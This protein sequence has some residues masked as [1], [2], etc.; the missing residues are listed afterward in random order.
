MMT[1]DE[2]SAL[3]NHTIPI[4][5]KRLAER[6]RITRITVEEM[7]ALLDAEQ[8]NKNRRGIVEWLK[9]GIEAG[10]LPDA[11]YCLGYHD[12]AGCFKSALQKYI[13]RSMTEQALRAGRS[14]WRM[15]KSPAIARLKIIVPEDAHCAIGLLE[16]VSDD[17][18]EA[19]Y[20]G[21]VAA[22]AAAPKDKSSCPLAIQM[23]EDGAMEGLV[24]DVAVIREH[25]LDRSKLPVVARHAFRLCQM[26]RQEEVMEMLGNSNVV[27][28]LIGRQK[29]GTVWG[30]DSTLLVIAAVRYAQ[31]DY[32]ASM[33]PSQV[34]PH[35]ITPLRL[36]EVDWYALDF[37]TAVGRVAERIFLSRHEIDSKRLRRAWFV[38]ESGKLEGNIVS[39]EWDAMPRDTAFWLRHAPEIERLTRYMLQRFQLEQHGRLTSAE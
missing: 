4:I 6:D 22:V 38:N 31:G 7:A 24:P 17:M 33:Q 34:E 10:R 13:R 25:L 3:L 5:Q 12:R 1:P 28:T 26:G 19:T 36:D 11:R 37:H 23:D 32:D 9:L 14:L 21:I 18:T 27:R 35:T 15:G 39:S 2:I 16:H 20:L 8:A 30:D 29:A